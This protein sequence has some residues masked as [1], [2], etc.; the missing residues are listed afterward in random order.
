[1]R[2]HI[3]LPVLL[4]LTGLLMLGCQPYVNIPKQAGD[5]ASHNPDS[6]TVRDVEVVAVRAAMEQGDVPRPLQLL[7]PENTSRLT[8]AAVANA[9]GDIVVVADDDEETPAAQ[10][11]IFVKGIRIRANDADVDIVR[12]TEDG[13]DQLVTVRLTFTI[14]SG[15]HSAG[16]RVWRGVPIED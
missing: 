16:V 6:R 1:M 13:H 10:G 4:T 11:V 15:W 9:L 12:P 3:T 5:S 7:L 14:P 8:Y 2:R